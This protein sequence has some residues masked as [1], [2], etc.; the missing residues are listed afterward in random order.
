MTGQTDRPHNVFYAE[1]LHSITHIT[2]VW[3]PIYLVASTQTHSSG[4]QFCMQIFDCSAPICWCFSR[5]KFLRLGYQNGPS[6]V[7]KWSLKS[8]VHLAAF[9]SS[10][11]CFSRCRIRPED[12]HKH[13]LR[14][15]NTHP[16]P[17]GSEQKHVC[18]LFCFIARI[19]QAY[20]SGICI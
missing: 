17:S 5:W 16:E 14:L 3:F 6:W 9:G 11:S 7:P 2:Y 12:T 13:T 1:M 4:Q 10:S 15:S 19:G 20:N 18:I 8:L